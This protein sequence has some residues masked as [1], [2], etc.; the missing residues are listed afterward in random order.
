MRHRPL[1]NPARRKSAVTAARDVMRREV[2]Q[3]V[4]GMDAEKFAV[5]HN[6]VDLRLRI[7][8]RGWNILRPP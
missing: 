7:R 5:N 6:D 4:A 2:F 3:A 1:H 8:E